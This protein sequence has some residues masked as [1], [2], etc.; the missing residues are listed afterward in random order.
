VA[1][2]K[3]CEHVY[4]VYLENTKI[5]CI[6]AAENIRQNSTLPL[7]TRKV[8]IENHTWEIQLL[9]SREIM[10]SYLIEVIEGK[11]SLWGWCSDPDDYKY[12]IRVYDDDVL[13]DGVSA[14][15][16]VNKIISSAISLINQSGYDFFYFCAST[17]RKGIFYKNIIDKFL[18]RIKGNWTYQIIDIDWFYFSK[19]NE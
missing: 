1:K 6:F 4:K 18:K 19:V 15:K 3:N 7:M 12:N 11:E 9:K 5:I 8:N 16:V 17:N 10:F 13:P 2:T 14:T